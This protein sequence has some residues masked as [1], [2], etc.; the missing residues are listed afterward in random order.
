MRST[1]TASD[2]RRNEPC[3]HIFDDTQSTQP[4]PLSASLP[5]PMKPSVQLSALLFCL[6]GMEAT[7]IADVDL[8]HIV[9]LQGHGARTVILEAGLGDTMDVWKD[10]QPRIAAG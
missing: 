10:I 3:P 4:H 7:A 8:H 2:V 6:I 9:R 1:C 5:T